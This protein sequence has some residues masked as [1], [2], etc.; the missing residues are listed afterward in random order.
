[1]FPSGADSDPRGEK[2]S[3]PTCIKCVHYKVSWDPQHPH[4]CEVFEIKSRL[5]PSFEVYSSA[6]GNCPSFC[7]KEVFRSP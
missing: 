1:M 7:L 3:Q 6:G 5:M 4:A 2:P